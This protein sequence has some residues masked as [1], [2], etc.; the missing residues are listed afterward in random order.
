MLV[1]CRQARV[2]ESR[3]VR[4]LEN[5]Y[6]PAISASVYRARQLSINPD[7][8]IQVIDLRKLRI[9]NLDLNSILLFYDC[10]LAFISIS[11]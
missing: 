7:E 5:P 10:E 3:R 2:A 11:L 8:I 4:A 6:R 9:T 1:L